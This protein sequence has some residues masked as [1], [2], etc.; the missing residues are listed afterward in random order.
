MVGNGL[1]GKLVGIS[2]AFAK[3]EQLKIIELYTFAEVISYRKP[4]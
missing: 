1:G 4:E 2:S 3:A